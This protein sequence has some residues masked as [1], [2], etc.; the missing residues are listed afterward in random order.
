MGTY[1]STVSLMRGLPDT[2]LLL[3]SEFIRRLSSRTEIKREMYNPY[4]PLT[5]EE[6]IEQLAIAKKQAEDGEVIDAFQASKNIREK[7]G[8]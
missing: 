7:Y 3:V 6:I 2:D 8:L 5:R 1:E 4:K